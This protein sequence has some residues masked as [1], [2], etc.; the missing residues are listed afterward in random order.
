[1]KDRHGTALN[2]EGLLQGRLEGQGHLRELCSALWP[3]LSLFFSH[4]ITQY[5]LEKYDVARTLS[6]VKICS[7]GEDCCEDAVIEHERQ[8]CGSANFY[9]HVLSLGACNINLRY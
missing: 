2:Y 4:L 6:V 7:E 8:D 1:M 5:E 3:S 9:H